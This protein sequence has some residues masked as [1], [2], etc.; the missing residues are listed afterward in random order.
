MISEIDAGEGG[1]FNHRLHGF[2]ERWY[3]GS[4]RAA[5]EPSRG[6]RTAVQKSTQP[7]FRPV[8]KSV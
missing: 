3:L 5:I 1:L 6:F 4:G 2:D 7:T 8:F